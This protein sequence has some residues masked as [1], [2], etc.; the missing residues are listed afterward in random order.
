MLLVLDAGGEEEALDYLFP[1]K[2]R[3]EDDPFCVGGEA[4]GHAEEDYLN[5]EDSEDHLYDFRPSGKGDIHPRETEDED[6]EILETSSD[7]E[8][9][10]KPV[11]EVA[12][13]EAAPAE[14]ALAEVA[15]L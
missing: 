4:S 8:P 15:T 5:F 1:I 9:I 11:V 13:A 14:I 3:M 7:N 12:P 2:E 10:T 6:I